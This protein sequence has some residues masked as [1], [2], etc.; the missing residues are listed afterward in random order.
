MM[1]D[2]L[3]QF[4]RTFTE[5][6]ND[7]DWELIAGAAALAAVAATLGIALYSTYFSGSGDPGGPAGPEIIWKL[8]SR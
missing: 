1:L 6:E 2:A 8:W 5:S 4:S 7:G 3:R